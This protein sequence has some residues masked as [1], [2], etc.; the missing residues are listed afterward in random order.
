MVGREGRKEAGIM[1]LIEIP[2]QKRE[3]KIKRLWPL[4]NLSMRMR[5]SISEY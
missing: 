2:T 3:R 4:A 1:N 5:V